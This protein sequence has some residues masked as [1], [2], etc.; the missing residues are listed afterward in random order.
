MSSTFTALLTHY[1]R[2]ELAYILELLEENFE[3][4]LSSEHAIPLDGNESK[5]ETIVTNVPTTNTSLRQTYIN[6]KYSIMKNLTR[7]KVTLLDNHSY[8]SICQCIVD[9][10]SWGNIP[11]MIAS[12]GVNKKVGWLQNQ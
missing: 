10:L 1:Q 9:F 7:P 2:I 8:V 5:K 4:D 12:C 11:H 6:R 3:R